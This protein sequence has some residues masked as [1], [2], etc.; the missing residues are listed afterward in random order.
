M[1]DAS[2]LGVLGATRESSSLSMPTMRQLK[3]LYGKEARMRGPYTCKKDGRRILDVLVDGRFR[4]MQV[5]R[6]LLEIK[7]GRRL[8]PTETVDHRD[9]DCTNDAPYNL[10]LL[11]RSGNARKSS[12]TA[13]K[14][15]LSEIQS[16]NR[17]EAGRLALSRRASGDRNGQ[18]KMS[19]QQVED[20]RMRQKYHGIVRDLMV[21][22]GVSR[23]SIQNAMKG[24]SYIAPVLNVA[25]RQ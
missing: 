12:R 10:Q 4:T 25:P 22:F 14:Y 23:R 21:E 9:E 2:I 6:V 18:A 17:T 8:L 24:M 15:N 19:M 1:V 11:T 13:G 20:I 16:H 5:A 3:R 7:L